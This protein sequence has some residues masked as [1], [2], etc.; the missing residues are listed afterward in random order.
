MRQD[1]KAEHVLL[2]LRPGEFVENY[3]PIRDRST[4]TV[5]GIVE[6]YRRP[7]ALTEALAGGRL[8]LWLGAAVGGLVLFLSLVWFVRRIERSLLEQQSRI[9]DTEALAMVGELS[10]AVAHS[11][12]N[13]LGSIRS[14][15]ELQ[16]ELGPGTPLDAEDVIRQVDRIEHLVRTLLTVARE[17]LDR[18]AR[19]ELGHALEATSR[20]FAPELAAQGKPFHTDWPRPLGEVA[21]DEVL[22][23]QVLA[24]VLA[25]AAEATEAGE[26]IRLVAECQ[27]RRVQV[28]V[29][30]A[31]R[32]IAPAQRDKVSQPFFTTKP[33]GLGLGLPLARRAVE[34]IGG[35]LSI[36]PLPAR[37]TRVTLTLPLLAPDA[38]AV[39]GVS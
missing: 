33:R 3:L 7:V 19:C 26:G 20:R 28:H 1:R 5:L 15:A 30:D 12:R 16:R 36:Q 6:L 27:G 8:R 9:V 24:S 2:S 34:R 39:R 14:A 4:G 18:S 32:G 10:A 21:L 22:L 38:P 31:G 13:P 29:E 37:G 35:Q 23:A 11:I 17:P 25:N